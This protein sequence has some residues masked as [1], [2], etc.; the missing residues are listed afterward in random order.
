MVDIFL[1]ALILGFSPNVRSVTLDDVMV[2]ASPLPEERVFY[3]WQS[4]KS[5]DTLLHA[6]QITDDLHRYFMGMTVD[7]QNFLAGQGIYI[8]DNP[9]SSHQ[10]A[11][12]EDAGS[13]IEVHVSKGTP[14]LDLTNDETMRN[15]NKMGLT[16]KQIYELNPPLAIKYSSTNGYWVLKGQTGIKFSAFDPD[17]LPPK[18]L[19]QHYEFLQSIKAKKIFLGAARPQLER[20]TRP[21]SGIS[22]S[23]SLSYQLHVTDT[24]DDLRAW[25]THMRH[26]GDL[27]DFYE[28]YDLNPEVA[29]YIKK[30]NLQHALFRAENRIASAARL[31]DRYE[32]SDFKRL[33]ALLKARFRP[34]EEDAGVQVRRLRDLQRTLAAAD[35]KTR[36]RLGVEFCNPS[37]NPKIQSNP[38]LKKQA[39]EAYKDL[40]I[41]DWDLA[42]ELKRAK[43]D[44]EGK[45]RLKEISDYTKSAGRENYPKSIAEI[46]TLRAC[47]DLMTI[48][49]ALL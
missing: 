44:T 33:Q 40:L 32:V 12:G 37:S 25:L 47:P 20:A 10:Y 8:A 4:K 9:S 24:L 23:R 18:E 3:R 35:I 45:Q 21:G 15:M 6:G 19:V 2:L 22:A 49:H 7:R 30:H 31:F 43:H 11:R 14:Y 38:E 41:N 42:E 48:L 28:F 46:E 16:A 34:T 5:G 17:R 27:E 1:L 29:S 13:L 36:L 26:F 39:N